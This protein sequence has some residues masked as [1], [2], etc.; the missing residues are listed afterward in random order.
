MSSKNF[1]R[2]SLAIFIVCLVAGLLLRILHVSLFLSTAL[3]GIA[4]LSLLG[5]MVLFAYKAF[6]QK[7]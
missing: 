2:R 6:I 5:M 3:L 7:S 4:M 1:Y